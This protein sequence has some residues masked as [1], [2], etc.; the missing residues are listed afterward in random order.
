M[1]SDVSKDYFV[2]DLKSRFRP[3]QDVDVWVKFIDVDNYKLGL[4]MFPPAPVPSSSSKE[5]VGGR[6]SWK[7]LAPQ[8][9]VVGTAVKYSDFGVFVD[10]GLPNKYVFRCCRSDCD[11]TSLPACWLSCTSAR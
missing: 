1:V 2:S 7:E 4:Q 10:I 6:L 9:E 3:G 8:Q 5:S 11:L